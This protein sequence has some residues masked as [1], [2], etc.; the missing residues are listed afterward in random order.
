[1]ECKKEG[2]LVLDE[3]KEYIEV[4]RE[5]S[6]I[7][8]I[9]RFIKSQVSWKLIILVIFLLLFVASIITFAQVEL[10]NNPERLAQINSEGQN[11]YFVAA[12]WLIVTIATVGY[13][14]ITPISFQGKIIALTSI[15]LGVS[16]LGFLVS[17]ITEYIIS[18][19]LAE[20]LGINRITEKVDCIICGW[21]QISEATLKEIIMQN[22]NWQIVVIDKTQRSNLS[23]IPNVKF[24]MGDPTKEETF[25]KANIK[26]AKNVILS[27]N[28]DSDALLAI[29][30]IRDLNPWINIVAKINDNEHVKLAEEVGADHVVS[31]STIGGKLLSIVSEQPTI[32]KWVLAAVTQSKGLEFIEQK[33]VDAKSFIGLTISDLKKK[34][35]GKAKIVGIETQ[36]GFIK[37]PEHTY[38]ISKGDNLVLL[39]NKNRYERK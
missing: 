31:P 14:D 18:T 10:I 28:N 26:Q 24:I 36:E 35:S 20:V 37:L 34:M 17:Q 4:E 29:H 11:P 25:E 33:A 23:H 8:K 9:K 32:V 2:M 12:Y 13:G 3:L 39:I 27:L 16:L 22:K 38:K 7:D 15:I 6:S 21:N 5:D 30:V 1:V 19:N